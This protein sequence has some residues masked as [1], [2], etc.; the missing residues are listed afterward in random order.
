MADDRVFIF[1]TLKPQA[2]KESAAE[3]L[4]RGMCEPSRAEAGCVF[5][6]LFTARDGS[7][8]FQFIECWNNQAALDA[9]REMPHYK[10]FREHLGNLMDGPPKGQLL[11]AVDFSRGTSP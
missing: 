11:E 4:L 3:E 10:N 6:N 2:G 9:H 1:A 5:Y 7:G 8:S